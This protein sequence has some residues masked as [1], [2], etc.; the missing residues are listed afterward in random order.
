MT[1]KNTDHIMLSKYEAIFQHNYN[2]NGN[3]V[4]FGSKRPDGWDIINDKYLIIIENKK[5]FNKKYYTECYSQ[6]KEYY[7]IVKNSNEYKLNQY[8]IYLVLGF[9]Y[10]DNNFRYYILDES[11]NKTNLDLQS[12]CTLTNKHNKNKHTFNIKKIHS[13]IVQYIHCDKSEDLHNILIIITLSFLNTKLVEY[14][15]KRSNDDVVSSEFIELLIKNAKEHISNISLYEKY[16]DL[17]SKTDIDNCFHICKTI[18]KAYLEDNYY[19]SKLFQQ[20]KNFKGDKPSKNEI[21]TEDFVSNIMFKEIEMFCDKVIEHK[22]QLIIL[23]PC[24]GVNNLIKPILNKYRDVSDSV[25]VKG[26]DIKSNYVFTSKLDLLSKS[27]NAN[28]INTV[29]DFITC[30]NKYDLRNDICICNPPYTEAESG[31]KSIEFIVTATSISD[32]C[33]FIFPFNQLKNNNTKNYRDAIMEKHYVHK[34]INLGSK[35]FIKPS[36]Q[37]AGTGD[38]A[39][40][41]TINKDKYKY[42]TNNEYSNTEYYDLSL[43]GNSRIKERNT[44]NVIDS[45]EGKKLLNDYKR[46]RVT[47]ELINITSNKWLSTNKNYNDDE[48]Y[49][50]Y[51]DAIIN[52]VKEYY[53]NELNKF[54]DN[55]LNYVKHKRIDTNITTSTQHNKHENINDINTCDDNKHVSTNDTNKHEN[56]ND[57][58][59]HDIITKLKSLSLKNF[60]IKNIVKNV[61]KTMFKKYKLC[62]VFG[63][64]KTLKHFIIKNTEEGNIPLYG[65]TKDNE[66]ISMI[67]EYSINTNDSKDDDIVNNGVICVNRNGS[68]GYCFRRKGKFA[69]T[70]DVMVFKVINKDVDM[71][72]INLKFISSQLTEIFSYNNKLTKE[73]FNETEVYILINN[74]NDIN[75]CDD[76]K[77]ENINDINKHIDNI[78]TSTQD[79]KTYD[80]IINKYFNGDVNIVKDNIDIDNIIKEIDNSTI[81]KHKL[82]TLFKEIKCKKYN[83]KRTSDGDIP[84]YGATKED[85]ILRYVDELSYNTNDSKDDDII[86]NGVICINKNG[87]GAGYCFRR[88]GKLSINTTLGIYKET[89]VILN[90][91]NLKFISY[92]LNSKFDFSNV[93]NN[94]RF[95]EIDVYIIKQ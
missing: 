31:H 20:F 28:Y 10:N 74:I 78:N 14:Y 40:I 52:D 15:N 86:N 95:N 47:P 16:F 89:Y 79:I 61:D 12:L 41:V 87:N 64:V 36:G 75:T 7:N 60:A 92:Q 56:I 51:V 19:I 67:S 50:Y 73:K 39:I 48:L 46:D 13:L 68:V 17:L 69:I 27:F 57:I 71:N 94:E 9:G 43:Y 24:I 18:Y 72:D 84:Y 88:K 45:K 25:I 44:E 54:K 23:D 81:E 66:P 85:K 26:T 33:C 55:L 91:I 37:F 38:I 65:S 8:T 22:K 34:I 6:I 49:N 5:T 35:I 21:W 90:D 30:Y 93:L 32:V 4:L 42:F 77:H 58:N 2:T 62:N 29:D 70:S 82:N 76:N 53:I 63:E 3:K 11:F 83:E 80:D 59:K 1:E